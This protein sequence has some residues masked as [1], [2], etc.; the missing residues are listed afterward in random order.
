[1]ENLEEARRRWLEDRPRY[2]EFGAVLKPRLIEAVRPLGI[3]SVVSVRTKEIDS[4]LKKLIL[5]ADHTY[6]SLGDKLGARIIVK[7]KEHVPLVCDRI[8][9]CFACGDFENKA[10]K[11]RDN[12]VGYLSVHVD[13][14]IPTD[15]SI[16]TLY[17]SEVWRA[18]L[19]IRT[20]AQHWWSEI[21][22]DSAYK[23]VTVIDRSLRRRFYI[24]AGAI[25]LADDEINRLEG[26]ISALPG[27]P[28]LQILKALERHYYQLTAERSNP[29]LSLDVLRLLYPLYGLSPN[30]ISAHLDQ[31][32]TEKQGFLRQVYGLAIQDRG[33]ASA[34][35]FQPEALLIYDLLLSMETALRDAWAREF[36]EKE[37]DR[38][39]IAFGFSP[40]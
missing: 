11:L 10:D 7:L 34:F 20:M 16:A 19:Q 23:S 37:L 4:L 38:I 8:A 28:E 31:L 6:M 22:H 9:M 24:L 1:M 39:A 40:D 12:E 5:K 14:G 15:D 29:E 26:E 2:N 21:A 32:L 35:L 30:E 17:P 27:V 33:G 3:P 36:P 13:V 18:E 25:E